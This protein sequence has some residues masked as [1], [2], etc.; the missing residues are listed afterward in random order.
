MIEARASLDSLSAQAAARESQLLIEHNRASAAHAIVV[1]ELRARA[2]EA[3][4]REL[5][6]V[7]RTQDR[8]RELQLHVTNAEAKIRDLEL[9]VAASHEAEILLAQLRE[10]HSMSVLKLRELHEAEVS[11]LHRNLEAVQHSLQKGINEQQRHLADDN[12]LR[13]E[14]SAALA[15]RDLEWQTRWAE[16]QS[17][18]QAELNG[19]RARHEREMSLAATALADAEAR[20]RAELH[21]SE[22]RIRAATAAVAAATIATTSAGATATATESVG[23]ASAAS[24]IAVVPTLIIAN[25]LSN[26]QRPPATPKIAAGSLPP[27]PLTAAPSATIDELNAKLKRYALAVKTLKSEKE[28]MQAAMAALES[29]LADSSNCAVSSTQSLASDTLRIAALTAELE[30]V[31]VEQQRRQEAQLQQRSQHQ[32]HIELLNS[33]HAAALDALERRAGNAE[34]ELQKALEQLASHQH[35]QAHIQRATA[36]DQNSPNVFAPH[37]SVADASKGK[38]VSNT[39]VSTDVGDEVDDFFESF[40]PIDDE[41]G[42]SKELSPMHVTSNQDG[43]QPAQQEHSSSVL[44][45][46]QNCMLEQIVHLESER[47][48]IASDNIALV[49]QIDLLTREYMKR[50]LQAADEAKRLVHAVETRAEEKLSIAEAALQSTQAEAEARVAAAE[51]QA[52]A[53]NEKLQPYK[54]K[55]V[56]QQAQLKQLLALQQE[57]SVKCTMYEERLAQSEAALGTERERASMSSSEF[58]GRIAMLTMENQDAEVRISALEQCVLELEQAQESKQLSLAE[59][60]TAKADLIRQIASLQESNSELEQSCAK[61]CERAQTA[62]QDAAQR[63]QEYETEVQ[64]NQCFQRIFLLAIHILSHSLLLT[65]FFPKFFSNFYTPEARC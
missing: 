40:V 30:R 62:E 64:F 25:D 50:E 28:T 51:A 42:I 12:D 35:L 19:E 5:D 13:E 46:A 56:Q 21:S 45:S 55:L 63:F 59:F 32:Q 34:C 8:E 33:T 49:A 44:S 31:Q 20:H 23:T 36:G 9:V 7:Q 6:L 18:L 37:L 3:L 47:D 4:E 54:V 29:Q 11:V 48:R 52:S 57:F 43:P 58:E 17:Q 22:E 24:S 60:E 26:L 16:S 65:Y 14:M 2:A 38:V 53:V 10:E 27:T 15:A 61:W 1:E 41:H 39:D